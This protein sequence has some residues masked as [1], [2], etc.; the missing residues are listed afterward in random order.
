MQTNRFGCPIFKFLM[1]ETKLNPIFSDYV[2][3]GDTFLLSNI[4]NSF[5]V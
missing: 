3:N 2:D 4:D 1:F 5:R